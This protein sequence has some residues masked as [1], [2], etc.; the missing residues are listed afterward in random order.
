MRDANDTCRL[1]SAASALGI[2]GRVAKHFAASAG[3]ELLASHR[4]RRGVSTRFAAARHSK[5]SGVRDP[6]PQTDKFPKLLDWVNE[7]VALHM[8]R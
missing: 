1:E 6:A 8:A 7:R 4:A 5:V 3:R 2:M